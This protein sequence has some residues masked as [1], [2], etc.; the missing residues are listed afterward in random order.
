[1][2]VAKQLILSLRAGLGGLR[3]ITRDEE[4]LLKETKGALIGAGERKIFTWSPASGLWQLL[5]TVSRAV[6]DSARDPFDFLFGLRR[7]LRDESEPSVF[8]LFGADGILEKELVLRRAFIENVRIAR[9]RGH[10]LLSVGRGENVHPEIHD[11]IQ[12]VRHALPA[13][14]QTRAALTSLLGQYEMTGNVDALLDAAAGLT[15]SRQ[16]DAFGLAIIEAAD[17]GT[18]VDANVVKTYKEREIGKK[19]QLQIKEPSIDYTNLIG[20]E[21][22]KRYLSERHAAL[23]TTAREANIEPGKGVLL[24]GPPGT[25]KSRIA[26]ATAKEW[27]V[28]FLNLDAAGLYGSLLGE[29][30]TRL[31]EALEIAEKMAPCILLID[32]VERGFATGDRDGGTQERVLG[33]MLTWMA[34]K[35]SPVFVM[36]TANFADRLPAALIRKGRIDEIFCLGFPTAEERKDVFDYYLAKAEPHLVKEDDVR[37]LVQTTE[38]WV[39]SEIEAII[40]AARFTAFAASRPVQT[41]DLVNEISR[42]V[43]V[44]RSMRVQVDHMMA[45]AGEYARRTNY[46]EQPEYNDDNRI[47]R[48]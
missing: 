18:D 14:E 8:F 33:K 11:E 21:L 10:L 3:L 42:T 43:P 2:D 1:M 40:N 20:H 25:G 12:T 9:S 44:S 24:V 47:I 6:D 13:R 7:R 15:A 45:W 17:Q 28:P 23:S 22:L 31:A 46:D 34:A 37:Q 41:F 32:E 38:G 26:E 29:S 35:T 27:G 19:A 16:Q 36:M 39:P 30:E 4:A 5:E 48:A